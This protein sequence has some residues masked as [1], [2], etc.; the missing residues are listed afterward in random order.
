M[1]FIAYIITKL[2][3]GIAEN[4]FRCV[5]HVKMNWKEYGSVWKVGKDPDKH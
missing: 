5:E 1:G 3:V 2:V 4:R